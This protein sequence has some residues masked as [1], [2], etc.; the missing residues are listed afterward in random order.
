MSV[1]E[2]LA[3]P[4]RFPGLVPVLLLLFG[5]VLVNGWTDAPNAIATAV[6]SGAVSFR[7]AVLLAAGCNAAG[8]WLT[9]L[10]LPVVADTVYAIADF[11]G[12]PS[13]AL[14]ALAAALPAI[15]LW[16]VAA[17]RFGIPTSESHALIAAVTGAAWALQGSLSA[18]RWEAW[19]KV[20]FGLV[21]S[22][23]A[24]FLLGG[25]FTRPLPRRSGYRGPQ[26]LGMAVMSFLHGAQDGQKF[27]GVVL[28]AVSLAKGEGGEV[29]PSPPLWLVLLISAVMALGTLMGGRRIIDKVCR[30]MASLPPREAF[31]ADLG[32]GAALAAATFWGLPVSTTHA[33]TAAVLGAGLAAGQPVSR[34][35]AGEIALAW[36]FTFPACLALGYLAA[37]LSLG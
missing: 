12:Q 2:F 29:F 26:L 14:T 11:R 6:A 8:V 24:G 37:R 33:K 17:W 4:G 36:V 1:S 9:S 21:F 18:V 31:A 34:R 16:A 7:S 35:A 23:L 3:L 28:L 5:V 32:A 27:V 30:D 20:L 22:V 13:A 19:G 25:L 10:T 15:V